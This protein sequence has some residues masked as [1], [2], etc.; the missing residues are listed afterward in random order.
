ML[1]RT[2][3]AAAAA[4]EAAVTAIAACTAAAAAGELAALL[5]I[6]A[7]GAAGAP[8][9]ATAL[10]PS[11]GGCYI[12]IL[13]RERTPA[14]LATVARSIG[15][16]TAVSAEPAAAARM[17]VVPPEDPEYAPVSAFGR[18]VHDRHVPQGNA[19]ARMAVEI[20][21]HEHRAAGAHAA[22]P[23]EVV[24]TITALS[25]GVGE[26]DVA[27]GD[28]AGIGEE[29]A[30]AAPA[31]DRVV[32]ALMTSWLPACGLRIGRVPV[33]AMLRREGDGVDR[34]SAGIGAVDGC[35]Q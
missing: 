19:G 13:A 11:R 30:L 33:R 3:T 25:L 12:S 28:V 18:I 14:A 4:A 29:N 31:V 24:A 22:T 23:T 17:N 9:R 35:D 6:R 26:R 1:P 5:S 20:A 27:D 10:R 8:V 32:A 21:A 2:A 7:A 34:V 16:R 15:P